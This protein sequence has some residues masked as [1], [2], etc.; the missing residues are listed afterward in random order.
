MK[1]STL[2]PIVRECCT[3]ST[4]E[5]FSWLIEEH[6]FTQIGTKEDRFLIRIGTIPVVGVCHLDTVLDDTSYE[7]HQDSG[8]VVSSELDDR[9]GLASLLLLSTRFNFTIVC[10]DNEEVGR[11]T[12]NF[13]ARH[14]EEEAIA[15][16]WIFELDR[17]GMD[18]VSYDYSE[19]MWDAMLQEAFGTLGYG[20][21]SDICKME[22]LGVKG[23][24]AAIGYHN[25]HS[26]HCHA[27]LNDTCIRIEQVAGFLDKIAYVKLPHTPSPRKYSNYPAG[28][29]SLSDYYGYD[30]GDD[31]AI[32]V[33]YPDED[34]NSK[35]KR[36]HELPEGYGFPS[37]D[38]LYE[39]RDSCGYMELCENIQGYSICED[40][41]NPKG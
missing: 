3:K 30:D 29:S 33:S 13:A 5:V 19:P 18:V 25:E 24:N 28:N 15:C 26:W 9:L 12:A 14:I 23:F 17:R 4:D 31:Y 27:D 39:L 21:F 11:S 35:M 36:I 2:E 32:A 1:V 40:C 41:R 16:N 34:S 22:S 38:S 6:G 8:L 37:S 20:S 10:C 7:Y